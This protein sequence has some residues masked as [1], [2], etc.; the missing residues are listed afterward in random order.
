MPFL[1]QDLRYGFR[2][3]RKQL[4]FTSLAILTLG[5]GIG[6]A[7]TIFS[8]I[9]NVLLDPYP[10]MNVDRVV[11][12]QIRDPAR[13]RPGG[14]TSF[15]VPEFL[16]Y[17][18]QVQSFEEVIGGGFEDV[19]YSTGQ[20]T[21]RFSGGL[22]TA[23]NFRFL[24]VQAAIGRTLDESDV[25]P[26]APPV[27]VMSHK[28]WIRQFGQ[29]PSVVGKSFVLNGVPTTLVGIMPPR[30]SKLGA[31]LWKPITLDRAD[32][33]GS[34]R[35]FMLQGRLKRGVIFEQA[36]AEL[37]VV[38]E[39][40]SKVY[41]RDYPEKFTVKV[42]SLIDNTVG[43]FR[44]TL[45][46]LAAAVGLLLLIACSNV[47]NM[48]L[49]RGTAR[50]RE[51]AIRSSLG[52]SRAR[53]VRQL[54]AESLLLALMGAALGCL[55]AHFG[56]KALVQAIPEGLIPR[57]SDIRVNLPVLVFSLLIAVLTSLLFG[58]I[59]AFQT[60]SKDLVEPLKDSGKGA[61]GGFRKKR[62]NHGLV[63]L[64]VALSLV[65][66][67]GAGLLMRSFVK[68]QTVSLGFDPSNVLSVRLPLPREQ[69]KT[70]AARKQFF[71]QLLARVQGLP[72]VVV[73]TATS[74]LPPY[75]GIRSE[76]DVPG[77]THNERWDA[78]FQLCSEGYLPTLKLRLLRGRFLTEAEVDDARKVAVVNQTLAERYF[79]TDDPIGQMLQ[80][81]L[82]ATL[83][84]S[85]EPDPSFEIVGIVADAKNQGIQDPPMPEAFVP[86]TVTAAFERGILVRTSGPPTAVLDS[87]RREVWAVDRSVAL[88]LTRSLTDSL[89]DFSY[90][91]PRFSVIVL[92][93]FASVGLVLVVLGVFSVVTYT[94]SRQTHEIGIRMALGAARADV[95][96]M[97]MGM[98]IRLIGIGVTVG[99]AASMGVTRV[100]RSQLF[101]VGPNDPA[102]L[103]IVT[104]LVTAAAFLACY[105]PARRAT[106]VDP[107][108]ALRYE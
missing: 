60:A 62:L 11:N 16:D 49:T 5:L 69:Y 75:G 50:E 53:L 102:T 78:I 66:V 44:T 77:K 74:T 103:A 45:Y 99:I 37:R 46:T 67:A 68:L 25:A 29:D 57:E 100:L 81:K 58:L 91:E 105:L 8:V 35:F 4:G 39:R 88:T 63:V 55:C 22:V 20:G 89:K 96:R 30:F 85:P 97:V 21:E 61:G 3:L 15:R 51:M 94:V 79:G 107:M 38:A 41:P 10:Y 14:R 19:L 59:P 98:G 52:A 1:A 64:E 87:V 54:L 93:V 86:Y 2:G 40:L 23:N 84:N 106:R 90:A 82:L 108:V 27:F 33:E 92:G 12:F 13:N 7:T 36:E 34:Q 31:D 18:E 70:V 71:S 24:G 32:P 48:L 28:L 65:L 104:V 6:G 56:L 72:G 47:A 26:G 9:Q 42:V 73:A 101:G 83:P 76:V 95:L 43:R 17:K 80:V